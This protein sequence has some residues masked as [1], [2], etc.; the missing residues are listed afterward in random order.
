MLSAEEGDQAPDAQQFG[1][2]VRGP[3]TRGESEISGNSE[4][5]DMYIPDAHTPSP[6][7]LNDIAAKINSKLLP[8]RR[9][10]STYLT[11]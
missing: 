5:L 9:Q 11:S 10:C 4:G 3:L 2:S 6:P 8:P 7:T 1:V